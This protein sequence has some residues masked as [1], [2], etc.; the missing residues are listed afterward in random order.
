MLA[1]TS[2]KAVCPR[3]VALSN[4]LTTSHGK[5][6]IFHHHSEHTNIRVIVVYMDVCV[7]VYIYGCVYIWIYIC[8]F[9]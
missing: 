6:Y 5:K 1:I 7:C 9:H 3:E 4:F 8:I 2:W